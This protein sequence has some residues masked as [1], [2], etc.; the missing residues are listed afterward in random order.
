MSWQG[1]CYKE[2]R[3]DS[4]RAK[5]ELFQSGGDMNIASLMLLI[6]LS[7]I[8][9]AD[10]PQ[11][12]SMQA[13]SSS[14]QV[15]QINSNQIKITIATGGGPYGP[16][17]DTFRVGESVPLVITMTNTSNQPVYVC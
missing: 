7:G 9:G 2:G 8:S 17:K 10:L 15:G 16:A 3:S 5:D 11:C 13:N 6:T 12:V 1:L 14:V 4:Q